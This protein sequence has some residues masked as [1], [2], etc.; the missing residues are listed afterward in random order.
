[1]T[2]RPVHLKKNKSKKPHNILNRSNSLE[3]DT[4]EPDQGLNVSLDR[5]QKKYEELLNL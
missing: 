5:L 2:K 4:K 1:M 3:T